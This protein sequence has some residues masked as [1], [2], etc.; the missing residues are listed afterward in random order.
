MRTLL[1]QGHVNAIL[2]AL[3]ALDQRHDTDEVIRTAINYFQTHAARMQYDTFRAAG[4]PIGSGSIESGV[5]RIV[6][7]RLK[8]ASLFWLPENAEEILYSSPFAPSG[9]NSLNFKLPIESGT[10]SQPSQDILL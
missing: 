5:R 8:G 7:L 6:N 2:D 4:L 9:S 10:Q 1:K 3:Q